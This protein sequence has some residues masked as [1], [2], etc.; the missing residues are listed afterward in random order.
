MLLHSGAITA[1][2]LIPDA[3]KYP[4]NP[5]R[6]AHLPGDPALAHSGTSRRNAPQYIVVLPN[7]WAV[8]QT[9]HICFFGGSDVLRA[10]VLTIANQWLQFAN[11]VF[12]TGGTNGKS[13][14]NQDK[15]EVRIGFTEPGYWSYIGTDG[16]SDDLVAKSLSSMNFQGFDKS[17]PAEPHFTGIVLHEFGHALGF[18]HE[19]QSPAEGCDKE[20]DWP[21]LYS[22]YKTSYG[23]DQAMVDANV[24]QLLADHRAYDW[25]APDPKSIMVYASDPQFL[26]KGTRSPCYFA[27]VNR[28]SLTDE[29][30]AQKTYPKNAPA[31]LLRSNAADLRFLKQHVDKDMV[32]ILSKQLQ[33][34]EQQLQ[35]AK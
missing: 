22:F 2:D 3:N 4:W 33:L 29:Q 24:R 5:E 21:K 7:R 31:Q 25:S 9:L 27:E 6:A 16:V 30:G 1:H 17:P 10:R 34:T 12:D 15:S 13:C 35:S 20:Y 11:L 19:H 8:G 18:H 32:G 26:L 23:W 28:L 14:Q